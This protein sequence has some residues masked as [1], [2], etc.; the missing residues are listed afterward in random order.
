[1]TFHLRIQLDSFTTYLN[2]KNLKYQVS[3]AQEVVLG[4]GGSMKK[5]DVRA[6]P[7]GRD[8]IDNSEVADN[9]IRKKVQKMSKSKKLSKSKKMVGLDFLTLGARLV[10]SKLRSAFV[11]A[12]ILHHLD[13]KQFIWFDMDVSG[14]VIG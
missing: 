6:E 4:I 10:S 14:Y 8:E 1:M 13:P 12:P 3:R 5:H 11:K 2:T 7:V 9:K